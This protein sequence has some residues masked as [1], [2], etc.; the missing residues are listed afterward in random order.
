MHNT[1]TTRRRNTATATATR[2]P[3]RRPRM[4]PPC[5]Q[6]CEEVQM[7]IPKKGFKKLRSRNGRCHIML[8]HWHPWVKIWDTFLMAA[9]N[10]VAW[11]IALMVDINSVA[12][13]CAHVPVVANVIRSPPDKQG[14]P[15]FSSRN[16]HIMA[17]ILLKW[18]SHKKKVVS[19]NTLPLL[20]QADMI[21]LQSWCVSQK[22]IFLSLLYKQPT[23]HLNGKVYTPQTTK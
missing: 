14:H 16:Q 11:D 23:S 15:L 8:A 21:S 1:W 5:A 12:H 20:C 13:A 19:G 22:P 4:A 6:T 17:T 18:C 7:R 10:F 9:T 2:K 3:C